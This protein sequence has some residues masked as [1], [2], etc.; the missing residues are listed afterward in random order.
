MCHYVSC[1]N[2]P[3]FSFTL[4]QHITL[5]PDFIALDS[6]KNGSLIYYQGLGSKGIQ[7]KELQLQDKY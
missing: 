6:I 5:H 7:K 1:S 4:L 3:D 2:R